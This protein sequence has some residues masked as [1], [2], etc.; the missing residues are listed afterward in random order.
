MELKIPFG[1]LDCKCTLLAHVKFIST[2]NP[3]SFSAGLL[4]KSSSLLYSCILS[5][6]ISNW[7]YLDLSAKP[8]TWLCWTSLGL[9]GSIIQVY[10]DLLDGIPSALSITLL[11][12]VSSANLLRVHSIPSFMSLKKSTASKTDPWG[13]LHITKL[14]WGIEPLTTTLWLWPSNQ[15]L[16]HQTLHPSN[17]YL[18]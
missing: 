6:I 14:P 1:F 9:H 18:S 16:I 2:R 13:M 4:S 10:Q 15:L 5:C 8:Y 11:T 7:D 3:K 12:L 17:P